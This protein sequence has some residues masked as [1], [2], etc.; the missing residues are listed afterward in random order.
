M[1]T[2]LFH[3]FLALFIVCTLVQIPVFATG[4]T[5]YSCDFE[6][7]NDASAWLTSG[8]G[9]W[10]IADN[11]SGNKVYTTTERPTGEGLLIANDAA[12]V[13][14]DGVFSADIYAINRMNGSATGII[15]RYTDANNYYMLRLNFSEEVSD[16]RKI[17]LLKKEG[18]SFS[19]LE[20]LT[21]TVEFETTYNLKVEA[22]GSIMKCYLNDELKFTS[23]DATHTSGK[24][25]FRVY[26]QAVSVDNVLIKSLNGES[27][28][29]SLE[30]NNIQFNH[31]M[32]S[33]E[34]TISSP[35][36]VLDI[37]VY[38]ISG[39]LIYKGAN[40]VISTAA[41]TKG[42]YIVRV[43]TGKGNIIEKITIK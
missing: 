8:G 14:S 10:E 35:E 25:G 5:I 16:S 37:N 43:M 17:Q 26:D 20:D 38:S 39:R 7:A 41:W 34:L 1:K 2:F 21:V 28:V 12:V 23:I 15:F 18:G 36:T 11:G 42:I 9:T 3:K 31:S 6:G 30:N 27:S 29:R 13:M 32:L 24:I 19:V 4:T 22:D 33:Q 40:S